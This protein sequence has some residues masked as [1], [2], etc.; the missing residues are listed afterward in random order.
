VPRALLRSLCAALGLT[1]TAIASLKTIY[2]RVATLYEHQ[3]WTRDFAG[4]T[5]ADDAVMTELG[6]ALEDLAKTAASV[7]EL[8]QEAELWLFGRQHLLPVDRILRDLARKAFAFIEAAALV[9]HGFMVRSCFLVSRC[10]FAGSVLSGSRRE[11]EEK[12]GAFP[13]SPLG[14]DTAGVMGNDSV[15]GRQTNSRAGKL[16]RGMQALE[17]TEQFVRMSHVKASAVIVNEE[18]SSPVVVESF[19]DLYHWRSG[20]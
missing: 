16:T 12:C 17:C 11:C 7:D 3:K 15:H 20:M 18:N 8:V 9:L 10:G 6:K 4:I 5:N 19:S 14:P 1:E 13:H 2:Q